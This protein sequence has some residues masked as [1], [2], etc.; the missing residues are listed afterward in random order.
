MKINIKNCTTENQR[1]ESQNKDVIKMDQLKNI[2]LG[3]T[4]WVIF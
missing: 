2:A 1:E 4:K 3:I